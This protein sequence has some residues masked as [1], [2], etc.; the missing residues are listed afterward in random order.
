MLYCSQQKVSFSN[1]GPAALKAYSASQVER[2][3]DLN[4]LA[5]PSPTDALLS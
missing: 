5:T 4:G 1:A 3:M 2:A